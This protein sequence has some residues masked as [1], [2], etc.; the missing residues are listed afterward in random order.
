MCLKSELWWFYSRQGH[1]VI[2]RQNGQTTSVA[3]SASCSVDAG[4][5]FTWEMCSWFEADISALSRSQFQNEWSYTSNPPY[6]HMA[7]KGSFTITFT[8][9]FKTN[10]D[11]ECK[12]PLGSKEKNNFY[13]D[14]IGLALL[15]FRKAVAMNWLHAVADAVC[16]RSTQGGVPSHY[17]E[18]E[19]SV[20][21]TVALLL[22]FAFVLQ[23]ES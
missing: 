20:T 11:E 13:Y 9:Y 5:L 23:S 16:L 17:I 1:G 22:K 2:C 21:L 18:N 19:T 15:S 12:T 6:V 8:V 10:Q 4:G 3:H 7:L 14:F